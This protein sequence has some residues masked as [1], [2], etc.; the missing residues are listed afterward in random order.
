MGRLFHPLR[1]DES[2]ILAYRDGDAS[3]FETL[4]RRHK[5]RLFHF[6]LLGCGH[7][8]TVE[9]IAHDVWLAVIRGVAA[10][11][12]TALF[13]TWLY[14]IARNRLIDHRRTDK[15]HRLRELDPDDAEHAGGTPAPSMEQAALCRRLLAALDSLPPEQ[16]EVFLLGQE[17]FSRA[18]IAAITG[19]APETVKS[20]VRYARG[21]LRKSL[22]DLI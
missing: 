21:Q 18:E 11:Q 8:E 20:R 4:Y 22:E 13:R 14:R 16:R 15:S 5:D 7:R 12:P 1:S 2:L 6:L 10:Y 19:A 9:D 17:G 3:A